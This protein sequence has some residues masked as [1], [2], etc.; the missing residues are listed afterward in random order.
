[1]KALLWVIV[2]S[3]TFSI[4]FYYGKDISHFINSFIQKEETTQKKPN[5]IGSKKKKILVTEE[6][7]MGPKPY[8]KTKLVN[9]KSKKKEEKFI[10]QLRSSPEYKEIQK[11]INKNDTSNFVY[12][13]MA[14]YNLESGPHVER[15]NEEIEE[16]FYKAAEKNP[17]KLFKSIEENIDRF[18]E[19]PIKQA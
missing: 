12:D 4:C 14:K 16:S 17:E 8:G 7:K 11:K 15:L 2:Y 13:F 9:I 1:M 19:S 3:S 18:N 6:K 5:L 10:D